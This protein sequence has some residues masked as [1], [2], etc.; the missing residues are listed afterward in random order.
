MPDEL[1][2]SILDRW[3]IL[4]GGVYII[5]RGLDN[6]D[7]GIDN[8]DDTYYT[9]SFRSKQRWNYCFQSRETFS[10]ER[11]AAS[12]KRERARQKAIENR[13]WIKIEVRRWDNE[14]SVVPRSAR[15]DLP[16]MSD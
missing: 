9:R 10:T 12:L 15:A 2:I 14:C 4:L 11:D 1:S 7:R 5:V 8:I 16:L 13:E 6:V 3:F